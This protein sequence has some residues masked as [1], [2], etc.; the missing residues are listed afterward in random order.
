MKRRTSNGAIA[1][2]LLCLAVGTFQI[3][4]ASA[5][6]QGLGG[7]SPTQSSG[8]ADLVFSNG[9]IVTVDERFTIAEAVAVKDDR[10]VAVGSS[11]EIARL[12][13][14]NTRTIDLRGR[15]AIPGLIDNH[16][17]LLR[18]GNTWELELRWDGIDSR[19]RAIELLRAR[20]KSVGP[21][22]WVFNI[23]GW[24]TAQFVDDRKP[25]TRE[26]LDAIAPD[27]PVALQESYY[28]V[29]LNSRALREF[30]IEAGKPDPPD[31]VTGSIRRDTSGKPTGV[32][33]G[34]IA[35][36]R[37]VAARMPKLAPDR[38]EASTRTLVQ[39][40]NRAGL[41]S[42]GVA[43]C[44]ADVLEIMQRW[45]AE[46]R[47]PVRVFCIGGA[48]AGSPDQV[49]RSI[50]QITRMKLFQG[51]AYIDDVVFGESVYTPL[52]DRMFAIDSD[53][54]PE[55]LA[56]WRRLAMEIAKARLPLHV[57]AELRD[58]I[59]AFLD[60][61][62]AVNKEYPIRN[63]RWALAHVNQINASQLERMKKLGMYAAVHPWAV[64]NGA[65]M[66]EGFGDGADDMPPLAT[67]QQSG[68]TWGLGS[69]GTA[70]NQYLPM[71][72]LYFAVTGKMAGGL[73]VI[74]QT[75]DREDALIAYTR[76]NAYFV[77]QENNLGSIQA[78]KLADLVVLD[79][80][81][82]TVPAD[83]IKDVKPVMTVVGGKIVYQQ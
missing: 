66:H 5:F 32:I 41:T 17:H 62:E 10:I 6:T 9:K 56:Q 39:D 42:F 67:I 7:A 81:Y 57:H 22:G 16:L 4:R 21:G 8:T 35:A 75:I 51:D 44:N 15:T 12:A 37:P 3:V 79:R 31:F 53:P 49:E 45:K 64:I 2:A 26:E 29:F 71:T 74:R 34:D 54:Q 28:Q 77:F 58:T 27:N 19:K 20:A 63:L 48:A 72:A 55:Q 82:L 78:G 24:A 70:A 50:P 13:G 30:G 65:I 36:T 47:L 83:Q 43:G 40:M 23:G 61:I 59:D 52:H 69:D 68:I 33:R 11:Q 76:K 46:N 1:A 73:K 60:Q 80:D 18:A 38:L 14:P 25:F